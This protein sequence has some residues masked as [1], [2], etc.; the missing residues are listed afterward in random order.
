MRAAYDVKAASCRRVWPSRARGPPGAR[1]RPGGALARATR[2]RPGA[3]ARGPRHADELVCYRSGPPLPLV[4][5]GRHPDGDFGL[6]LEEL[7]EELA[8][9]GA[10]TE[11]RDGLR[12]P[13][14][15]DPEEVV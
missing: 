6:A 5:P 11:R 9:L 8:D 3:P 14:F 4:P 15:V 7:V 1:S 12:G 10:S 2:A 13:P